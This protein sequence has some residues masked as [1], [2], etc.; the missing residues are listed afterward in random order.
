M[1]ARARAAACFH[2][3]EGETNHAVS[4]SPKRQSG[5]A[6][7]SRNKTTVLMQNLLEGEAEAIARKAIE[8]AKEGVTTRTVRSN[9]RRS[10]FCPSYPAPVIVP[11]IAL[12]WSCY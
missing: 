2:C 3:N 10:Q 11:V 6:R 8:M 7:G 12:L 9:E 5:R 4:E 1:K